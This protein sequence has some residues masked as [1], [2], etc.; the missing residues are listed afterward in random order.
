MSADAICLSRACNGSRLRNKTDCTHTG[1]ARKRSM[2]VLNTPVGLTNRLLCK[3]NSTGSAQ[4]GGWVWTK[5]FSL[6]FNWRRRKLWIL[7][8]Y[9]GK[10]CLRWDFKE[11]VCMWVHPCSISPSF[12]EAE[13][14]AVVYLFFEQCDIS[15]CSYCVVLNLLWED[16]EVIPECK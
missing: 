15:V 1:T 12:S 10:G 14:Q 5:T 8:T 7:D 3:W 13:T 16:K 11:C 6:L 9:L 4:T 2:K